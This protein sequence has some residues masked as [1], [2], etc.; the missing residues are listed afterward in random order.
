MQW[1]VIAH[2]SCM[3]TAVIVILPLGILTARYRMTNHKMRRLLPAALADSLLPAATASTNASFPSG[4]GASSLAAP[5]PSWLLFH[6]SFLFLS[7]FLM[8]L[9]AGCMFLSLSHHLQSLHSVLGLGIVITVVFVQPRGVEEG[10]G[11]EG[12][13]QHRKL[14]WLLYAA[15]C[16]NVVLGLWT[17]RT[18]QRY[19]AAA[20]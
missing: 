20:D 5:Q 19:S 15:C 18:Q 8:L 14:G 7:G 3:L 6:S 17:L 10:L 1:Y 12:A 16:L 4:E 2:M 9:G 11:G 13:D